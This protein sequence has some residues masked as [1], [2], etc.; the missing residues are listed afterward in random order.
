MQKLLGIIAIIFVVLII[1]N[2]Q[3]KIASEK[4]YNSSIT[5]SIEKMTDK[6]VSEIENSNII[7]KL[8]EELYEAKKEWEET[9]KA[10]AKEKYEKI[11]DA[12]IEVYNKSNLK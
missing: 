11:K 3:R 12:L 8:Q 9:G 7:E 6:V 2:E 10:E 5:Q 1:K 4:S